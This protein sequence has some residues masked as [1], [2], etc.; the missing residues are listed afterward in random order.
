MLYPPH[1]KKRKG[2][3]SK[4]IEELKQKVYDQTDAKLIRRECFEKSRLR[5]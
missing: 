2:H 4:L 1:P 5:D 3:D